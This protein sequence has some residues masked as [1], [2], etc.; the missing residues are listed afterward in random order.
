MQF[1]GH[2]KIYLFV[3][4]TI[5]I[6]SFFSHN[7]FYTV[8][9]YNITLLH[10]NMHIGFSSFHTIKRC[11]CLYYTHSKTKSVPFTVRAR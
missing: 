1:I 9:S 4:A 8:V 3:T 6:L 10:Y 11:V 2:R 5:I 7:I